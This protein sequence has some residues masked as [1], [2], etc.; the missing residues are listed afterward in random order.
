MAI[1]ENSNQVLVAFRHPSKLAGFDIQNGRLLS[2]VAICGDSDDLFVD[3]KRKRVYVSCGEGLSCCI[4]FK[5]MR[6][7]LITNGPD[8]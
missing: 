8:R 7:G 6:P 5:L 3:R 2:S 1:D 4:L